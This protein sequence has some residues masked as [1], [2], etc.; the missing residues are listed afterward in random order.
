M[1]AITKQERAIEVFGVPARAFNV[2]T[3]SDG[4]ILNQTIKASRQINAHERLVVD[5]R[6]DDNCNNGHESFAITADLYD[7]RQ[8]REGGLVA[9]GCLHD[10]IAK[11]FPEFARLIPWHLTST[12]GPMHYIANTVFL[13]GDRDHWGLRAGER[14][15]IVNGKTKKP[16]WHLVAID[17]NGAEVPTYK[18]P[19]DIDSDTQPA[20]EY[21]LEWRPWCREG[22]GKAR[23]LDAARRAAVWPEATDAELSAEPEALKA[24]LVARLPVLLERFKADMLA[25]GFIYPE[26]R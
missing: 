11:H 12:D 16:A 4:R 20:C 22:E 7:S 23:E 17:A 8:K 6:F 19:R 15:Q 9:C 5:L 10:D 14:R 2:V 21:R 18:L 3:A 24:A 1:N 13:A 25:V 26:P